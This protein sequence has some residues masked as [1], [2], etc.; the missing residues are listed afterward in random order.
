MV[1]RKSEVRSD[2]SEKFNFR[3]NT[4]SAKYSSNQRQDGDILEKVKFPIY[5]V[6]CQI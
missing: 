6:G 1:N 4:F 2:D 5:D 3:L